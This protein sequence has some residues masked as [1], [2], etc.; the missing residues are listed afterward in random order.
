MVGAPIEGCHHARTPAPDLR[1]HL[2]APRPAGRDQHR[3]GVRR[4]HDPLGQDIVDGQ[5]MNVDLGTNAVTST[6]IKNGS[7]GLSD[8]VDDAVD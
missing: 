1:Q 2:L 5:V 3:D 8:L 7:V 6:K 4:R